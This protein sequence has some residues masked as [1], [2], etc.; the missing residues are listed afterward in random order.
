MEFKG[1]IIVIDSSQREHKQFIC[2][3]HNKAD[4]SNTLVT[5]N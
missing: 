1:K 3:W 4:Y 2:I 5:L